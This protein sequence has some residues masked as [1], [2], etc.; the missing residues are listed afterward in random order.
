MSADDRGWTL[1]RVLEH[2]VTAIG[3]GL[4]FVTGGFGFEP[5]FTLLGGLLHF[6]GM[7]A[8]TW[9]PLLGVF[10]TIA[11]TLSII[12]VDIAQTLFL[13]GAVVYAGFLTYRLIKK[14]DKLTQ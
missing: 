1:G 3:G 6:V 8:G 12:P 10:N 5:I 11:S 9:F 7:T 2:P 13:A 4:T 14:S